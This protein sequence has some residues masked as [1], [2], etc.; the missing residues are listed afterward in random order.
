[1]AFKGTQKEKP[2]LLDHWIIP[3]VEAFA[4]T[5]AGVRP[6]WRVSVWLAA[7]DGLPLKKNIPKSLVTLSRSSDFSG[8][9]DV[10]YVCSSRSDS[11]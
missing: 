1:M 11:W 6:K 2:T 7:M 4:Q 10:Y 8:L 9:Q 5:R 3:V